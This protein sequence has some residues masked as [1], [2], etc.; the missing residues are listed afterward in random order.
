MTALA[1]RWP[2]RRTRTIRVRLD[3]DYAEA[4]ETLLLRHPYRPSIETL[5]IRGLEAA[6]VEIERQVG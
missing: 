1:L 5:M 2:K 4:V 3:A 6:V